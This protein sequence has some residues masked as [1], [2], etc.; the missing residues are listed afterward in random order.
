MKHEEVITI[1]D[2]YQDL[3]RTSDV[4]LLYTMALI[5]E[6]QLLRAEMSASDVLSKATACGWL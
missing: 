5:D 6:G 3:H 4:I 1:N 2:G